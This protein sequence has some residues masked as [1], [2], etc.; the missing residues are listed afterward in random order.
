MRIVGRLRHQHAAGTCAFDEVVGANIGHEFCTWEKLNVELLLDGVELLK[1][2]SASEAA[3]S[4]GMLCTFSS[5]FISI[6]G[7]LSTC[8]A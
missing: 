1:D 3:G 5:V 6:L 4:T 8:S 2:V 7:G